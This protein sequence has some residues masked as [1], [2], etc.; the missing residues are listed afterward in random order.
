M[1][2]LRRIMMFVFGVNVVM[3]RDVFL[4]GVDLIMFDLEDVVLLK[5]KDFVCVLV[6]FVLKIFDYGNIEIVVWINVL[7]V[8]G[9]E[10]IEV[11]VLVGVDVICLLK[12]EI[13]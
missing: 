2:C 1:E 4:Y 10:D 8:G 5:E 6:Y 13:V 11:M 7:D 3:L 12:I 9:V